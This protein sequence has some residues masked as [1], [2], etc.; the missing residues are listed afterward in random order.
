VA[1]TQNTGSD[2]T[3]LDLLVDADQLTLFSVEYME[4]AIP[5]WT[6]Q[7][8]NPETILIEANAQMASE[9]I[10][11]ATETPDDAMVYLGTTVYGFPIND[12]APAQGAA[13]ITFAADTPATTVFQGT[14]ISVP[15]PSGASF[16]FETDRDAVAPQGG[17]DVDVIVIASEYGADQNGCFGAGE[18]QEEVAGVQSIVVNTTT[19]GLDQETT[20]DYLS[21]FSTYLSILTARPILPVDF[22]RRAQLNPRVGRAVSLDLYQPSNTQGG[23]GAPRDANTHTNVERCVTT[24]I[25]MEDGSLPPDDLMLE[26]WTDLDAN[27]EVNFLTYVIPPGDNG[28]YTAIDVQAVIRPYPGILDADA[29]AQAQDQLTQWLDPANWGQVPGAATTSTWATDNKVRV[30]EAVDWLNRAPAIFYVVSVQLKKST[31]PGWAAGDITLT[32]AVPMPTVGNVNNITIG[33]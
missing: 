16:I 14:E 7:P 23:Y 25:A 31:D 28:V 13:T 4:D 29:I 26:V 8:A 24:V 10:D 22:S 33:S 5:G 9:V 30:F 20:Q 12:G 3:E 11:A 2:Y 27:R 21:R 6:S 18:F 32:G 15:H 1:D 19:G 17:G